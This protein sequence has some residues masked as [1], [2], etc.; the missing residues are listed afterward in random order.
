MRYTYLTPKL[1]GRSRP[2]MD[3][4]EESPRSAEHGAG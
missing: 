1:A 2:G 4:G 3:R